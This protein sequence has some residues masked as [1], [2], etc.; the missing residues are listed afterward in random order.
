[1]RPPDAAATTPVPGK[2]PEPQEKIAGKVRFLLCDKFVTQLFL[3]R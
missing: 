1:M 2:S 3:P